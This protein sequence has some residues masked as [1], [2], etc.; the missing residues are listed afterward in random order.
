MSNSSEGLQYLLEKSK[1]IKMTPEER[2]EQRRSFAYGNTHIENSR[3]TR[4][5]VDEQAE[6]LRAAK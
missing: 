5:V 1:G 3:I 4:G 6:K 2:E